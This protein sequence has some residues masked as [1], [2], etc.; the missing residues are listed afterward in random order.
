M[1]YTFPY[2][3]KKISIQS[4]I[5]VISPRCVGQIS[6]YSIFRVTQHNFSE[7][8][9]D[10]DDTN[11][12]EIVLR[13]SETSG[14]IYPLMQ[15]HIPEEQNPQNKNKKMENNFSAFLFLFSVYYNVHWV[16][17]CVSCFRTSF[18]RNTFSLNGKDG[19]ALHQACGKAEVQLQAFFTSVM[20]DI[21]I[22]IYM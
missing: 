8:R 15:H 21:Y 3:T 6:V 18:V 17:T 19:C 10:T 22:Y 13:S 2:K 16:K 12:D 9:I 7:N 11:E 4:W 20:Y 5:W 1:K 14:T